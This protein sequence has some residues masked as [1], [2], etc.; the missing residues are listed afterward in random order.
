M[1]LD[2]LGLVSSLPMTGKDLSEFVG[3]AHLFND[4]ALHLIHYAGVVG[5]LP[6]IS[7]HV[8]GER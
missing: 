2:V 8:G 4:A 3:V 1:T 7:F 6:E 5:A